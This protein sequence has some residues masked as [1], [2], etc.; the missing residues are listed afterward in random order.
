MNADVLAAIQRTDALP[1]MP[2]IVTR[3]FEIT[4]EPNYRQ[5]D[6]I[7]LLST[8]PGV[9]A[10]IL[11]LANSPLFGVTRKV[12]SLQQAATLLGIKRI[13]TLVMGRC[14]VQGLSSTGSK[15]I[16]SSYY[17][18]R[19]L[20]TGVLAARFA[21]HTAPSFREEAFMTG[22]FSD[23]GI[24]ILARTFPQK[25]APAA[26]AYAPRKGTELTAVEAQCVG[27]THPLVS[28]M[29]LEKWTL[30]ERMAL[31]V[32][33][34]HDQ[35]LPD[36]LPEGVAELTCAV[37]AAS[38]IARLLCE[39]PHADEVARICAEAMDVVKLDVS[40]LKSVL[41]AV[42]RDITELAGILKIDVIPSKVYGIIADTVSHMLAPTA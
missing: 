26:D 28:A 32:R 24:V 38:D 3:F 23:V 27:T 34:H 36:G 19:S 4:L 35:L 41:T 42:E 5:E 13:R 8:D 31:A 22:L 37:H 30:P 15:L 11:R 7:Q 6:I 16:D 20:A 12:G 14:L 39:A 17:W 40:V 10:D 9:A 21:D 18:R 29:V 1:S 33:H 2:Q 25:Y